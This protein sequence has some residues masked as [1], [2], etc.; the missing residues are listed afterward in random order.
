MVPV[1][2]RV[3][4]KWF[5][6]GLRLSTSLWQWDLLESGSVR[7]NVSSSEWGAWG[8]IWTAM[9]N[10]QSCRACTNTHSCTHMHVCRNT[11][12]YRCVHTLN[13][14]N[15][16]HFTHSQ[17][18]NA[19]KSLCTHG[20]KKP[21]ETHAHTRKHTHTDT[22]PKT[23]SSFTRPPPFSLFILNIQTGIVRRYSVF[24]KTP[25]LAGRLKDGTL[26]CVVTVCNT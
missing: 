18:V 5:Q 8:V 4:N 12:S 20:D 19:H 9:N 13:R 17:H 24:S 1:V 3:C 26:C 15:I 6:A 14:H 16:K 11:S 21:S 25:M 10:S 23:D 7:F 2:W 22:L